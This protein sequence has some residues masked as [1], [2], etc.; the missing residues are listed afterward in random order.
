MQPRAQMGPEN[1]DLTGT[2]DRLELEE[3]NI[4]KTMDAQ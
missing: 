3:T 4:L 2:G 1:A